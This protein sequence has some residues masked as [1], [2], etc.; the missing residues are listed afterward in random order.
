MN[1]SE[2]NRVY[3]IL[4]ETNPSDKEYNELLEKLT[5]INHISKGHI[6]AFPPP[7]E[8][9]LKALVA[10]QALVGLIRDGLVT[11]A[12]LYHERTSII[13]SRIFS[14]VKPNKS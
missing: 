8:T 3:E 12:V 4:V 6:E 14:F 9:G 2:Y 13:T 10:N 11:G 7:P 5:Q 1:E